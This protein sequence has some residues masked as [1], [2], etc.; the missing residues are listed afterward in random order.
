[1]ALDQLLLNAILYVF[2]PL[3]LLAGFGDW[4]FHRKA[5]ISK[6]AGVIESILHQLMLAEV[7]LPLVAGLFLQINALLIGIMIAGFVLH[8]A[9]VFWDLRYASRHRKISPG[10]QIVHSFQELIPLT[11]LSL[12]VFLHWDQFVALVTLDSRAEFRLKWKRELLPTSYLASL[13]IVGVLLVVLPFA[14]ELWRCFR[15]ETQRRT[16]SRTR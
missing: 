4:L 2:I 1:M 15:D 14:E 8:E 3:W 10:E 13:L 7:G 6:N 16:A 5:Q 11:I 9:T 12:V